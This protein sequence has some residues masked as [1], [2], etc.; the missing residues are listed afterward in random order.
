MDAF[1]GAL[2]LVLHPPR[3]LLQCA[4]RHGLGLGR[5]GRGLSDRRRRGVSIPRKAIGVA[6]PSPVFGKYRL[7]SEGWYGP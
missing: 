5:E 4:V 6:N 1:H 2:V 7:C 3:C